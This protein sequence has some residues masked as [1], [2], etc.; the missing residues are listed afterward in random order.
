M[1]RNRW[2]HF[3]FIICIFTTLGLYIV[4]GFRNP[5]T[6][7]QYDYYNAKLPASFDG[8]KIV[9]IS[10][11]HCASFGDKQID[12]I[13]KI[14]SSKPDLIVFTGDTTDSSHPI[15]PLID[16][17]DGIKNIAP[18]YAITGNH[19]NYNA[20]LR[21]LYKTYGIPLLYSGMKIPIRTATDTIYLYGAAFYE[22]IQ[23]SDLDTSAF[24]ILLH[25]SSE[26][27]A[28]TKVLGFDLILSGHGHGGVIR[29]PLI[30]G[31]IGNSGFLPDYDYGIY[32]SGTSTLISSAGLGD[33]KVPRFHNPP[34]IV[35]ITLR[36]KSF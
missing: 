9:M 13:T 14:Q 15:N 11:L 35:L 5:L 3:A 27:F 24:N 17:L 20:S 6:T 19:D 18:I 29:L 32:T 34:E 4:F 1:K 2:L 30:G 26:A 23:T 36:S 31:L 8:Y 12:L 33:A 22:S 16:L 21:E 7:T 28:Y 10:D 25:H